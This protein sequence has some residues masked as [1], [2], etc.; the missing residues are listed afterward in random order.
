MEEASADLPAGHR[1]VL[2][3]ARIL[4]TLRHP[5]LVARFAMRLGYLPNPAAPTRYN[6]LMLWRKIVDHN[7]LFVT[8]T[9]KLA[10]KAHIRAACPELPVPE[11]LW[12][13][14]NPED[15]P[16]ALLAGQVVVKTN[17]GCEMNLFVS[18][19]QPER[20]EIVRKTRRW[21][22]KRFGRRSGEWAYWP[23][24]PR[25]SRR[26]AAETQRQNDRHRHQGS[27]LQRRH[28]PCL[29][30]G[31]ARR[32]LASVRWRRASATRTRP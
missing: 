5:V 28:Q 6:E 15:I 17:H 31:Q 4:L 2:M 12:S 23:I 3:A 13:G 32:A 22:T 27:C 19:G 14:S 8:L 16:A 25:R 9:D 26:G 7:P 10:A 21:L 24:A 20:A 30:R 18:D 11:T 1:L 29:G